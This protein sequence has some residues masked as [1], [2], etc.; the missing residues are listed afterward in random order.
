MMEI[1]A[2]T[3]DEVTEELATLSPSF[4][5]TDWQE[6]ESSLRLRA[7]VLGWTGD[8]LRQPPRSV[9]AAARGVKKE[10]A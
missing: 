3:D 4:S 9:L 7:A 8:A 6:L 1:E 5:E 2:M 10:A